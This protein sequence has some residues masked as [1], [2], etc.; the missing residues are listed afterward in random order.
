MLSHRLSLLFLC[1]FLITAHAAVKK[2]WTFIT[3]IAAANSLNGFDTIDIQEMM[4]VGSNDTVNVVVYLTK[5]DQHG[6]KYTQFLYVEKGSVTQIGD[7]TVEDSGAVA[8]LEKALEFAMTQYPADHYCVDLWNHGSGILNR[9]GTMSMRG[10]CYDD[11]TGSYL[12]DRDCL[13]ALTYAKNSLNNGKNIDVVAVDA[14]LMN[15][16]EFA[17][18]LSPCTD[19][20]V[21]SET[22]VP[23]DGFEYDTMLNSF[24]GNVPTPRAFAQAIVQAYQQEYENTPDYTL[25]AVDESLIQAVV[26]NFNQI[27]TALNNALKGPRAQLVH[28][29]I[30]TSIAAVPWFTEKDYIDL[31]SFYKKVSA[32]MYRMR[33][34]AH[35]NDALKTALQ[36]G[37]HLIAQAVIANVASSSYK[38]VGGISFYFPQ[39]AIDPSYQDLYWTEKNPIML[40]FLKDYISH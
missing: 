40:Q 14:C 24:V 15:M 37:E 3:Y 7:I 32:N 26:H 34:S 17:Y 38:N 18:T 16:L 29:A 36:K 19:F 6:N 31:L 39:H 13:H 33:L 1:C 27:I 21:G 8:T 5:F 11:D 12:T 9:D 35:D 25:S 2:P 20:F 4:K 28:S 23:G 30:V 22:T 10:V